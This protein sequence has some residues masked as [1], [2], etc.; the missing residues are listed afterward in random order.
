MRNYEELRKQMKDYLDNITP[1]DLAAE[2]AKNG[3]KFKK[4]I[5]KHDACTE[6][7]GSG[8]KK[9]GE[10]CVHYLSCLCPRC[11][12]RYNSQESYRRVGFGVTQSRNSPYQD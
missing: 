7:S 12:P 9:N 5:C 8:R 4:S 1:H 3:V 2:L 10:M 11:T 6:C